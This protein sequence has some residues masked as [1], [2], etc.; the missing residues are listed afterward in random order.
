METVNPS[1]STLCQWLN[2]IDTDK[3][4]VAPVYKE[5]P[6]SHFSDIT[7]EDAYVYLRNGKV[8]S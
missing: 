8:S 6:L 7:V 2:G 3:N 4:I 5:W 1:F